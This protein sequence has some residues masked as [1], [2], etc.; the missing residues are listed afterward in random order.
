MYG[1]KYSSQNKINVKRI[2]RWD[3]TT[4]NEG[5]DPYVVRDVCGI[6]SNT[7]IGSDVIYG[8]N[9]RSLLR[10]FNAE[11]ISRKFSDIFLPEYV[12]K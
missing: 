4:M 10:Q 5:I 11:T 7:Y 9:S 1:I 12:S 8:A 6:N 2:D 3:D